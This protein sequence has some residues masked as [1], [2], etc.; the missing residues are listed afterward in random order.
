MLPLAQLGRALL[1]G[2]IEVPVDLEQRNASVPVHILGLVQRF[3]KKRG[4]HAV[5]GLRIVERQFASVA[6]EVDEQLVLLQ[7]TD[8][9][10]PLQKTFEVELG[11]VFAGEQKCMVRR[12]AA[13]VGTQEE[14]I[15]GHIDT[16]PGS[17]PRK[18]L[19]T[20]P[21]SYP[22]KNLEDELGLVSRK[23]L[24]DEPGS[25]SKGIQ[26]RSTFDV[27]QVGIGADAIGRFQRV[28]E[29]FD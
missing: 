26:C 21:G 2:T 14:V 12:K 22:R 29:F 18:N 7:N 3:Q 6:G 19:E 9:E 11:R 10:F 13:S 17:Y 5:S 25:V 4:E 15:N 23:N 24:E 8:L 1:H 28:A 27:G 16:E 20:E